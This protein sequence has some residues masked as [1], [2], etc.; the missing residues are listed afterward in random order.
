VN[1]FVHTKG[2]S[3]DPS[4]V[5]YI[6]AFNA[7]GAGGWRCLVDLYDRPPQDPSVLRSSM[8]R[9]ISIPC[10]DE[11]EANNTKNMILLARKATNA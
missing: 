5:V 3:F 10:A 4:L 1:D 9:T 7:G 8:Q 2:G 6:H 11:A